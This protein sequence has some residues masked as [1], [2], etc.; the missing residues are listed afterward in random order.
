MNS[1]EIRAKIDENNKKIQLLLTK[2]ILTDEI[3]TLVKENE[4]LRGECKNHE[5]INGFCKYCDT[6]I[7]FV[8]E[9][10]G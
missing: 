10:N 5:F 3:K 1:Y 8:E 4:E 7:D 6:P 2:F 9:N